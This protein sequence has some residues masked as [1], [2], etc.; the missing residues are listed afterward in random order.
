M[1]TRGMTHRYIKNLST[2][3]VAADNKED[4]G[5]WGSTF[6]ATDDLSDAVTP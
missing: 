3:A 2:A 5:D 1:T 6:L 4:D